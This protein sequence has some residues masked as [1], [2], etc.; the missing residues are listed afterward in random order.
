LRRI[1]LL[2]THRQL[3]G[4]YYQTGTHAEHNLWQNKSTEDQ[5]RH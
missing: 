3:I 5:E 1:E 4:G 2:E